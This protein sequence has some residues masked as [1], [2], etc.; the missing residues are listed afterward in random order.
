MKINYK[1]LAAA[2]AIP[3]AVGGVSALITS[4]AM[5]EFADVSKPP[6]SPPG[7]IFPVVWSVLYVLMGIASYIIVQSGAEPG[8]KKSALTA[9]GAQ[10]FFN[11]FWSIIFFD[12]SAYL[13]AFVWLVIMFVLIIITYGR[14]AKIA[15]SAA[16]LLVPYILLVLFAAHLNLGVY[17][18]N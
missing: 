9:Y 12:F 13:F 1:R 18:L 15:K 10:L 2:I 3:L 17:L 11:F 4:G 14:F 7:W 8:E 16:Y 5:K 6:L